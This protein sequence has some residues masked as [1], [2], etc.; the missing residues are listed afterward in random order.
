MFLRGCNGKGWFNVKSII[1]RYV[2]YVFIIN[3]WTRV[4]ENADREPNYR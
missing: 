3:H 1:E 2:R 4:F